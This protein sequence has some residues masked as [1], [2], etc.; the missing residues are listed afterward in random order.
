M[1]SEQVDKIAP[2]LVAAQRSLRAVQKTAENPHFKSRFA[3]LEEIMGAAK[4][5]L[6]VQEIAILQSTGEEDA[7]GFNLVTT[8][9][10]TSGQWISGRVRM[11]LER[12]TAQAAGSAI[13]YGRR[14]GLAAL[15]GIVADEDDD[16]H[17][18][19]V[20]QALKPAKAAANGKGKGK[21]KKPLKERTEVELLD[22]RVWAEREGKDDLIEK[23]NGEL[24]RR[25][26]AGLEELPPELA[27]T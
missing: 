3:P 7:A 4:E 8:L 26:D 23:I 6:H 13:T 15:L 12:G 2:A 27:G 14:Y 20:T 25:R 22:L 24:E 9:L 18:A 5:A 16:G 10:H 1:Q 11:P 17:A 21:A 19:T